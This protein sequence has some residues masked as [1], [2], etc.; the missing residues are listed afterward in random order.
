[1]RHHRLLHGLG[2]QQGWG[3]WLN[4]A[5]ARQVDAGAGLKLDTSLIAFELAAQGSGVALGRSALAG[6]ALAS[7]RLIVPFGLA[8]PIDQAFQLLRTAGSAVHPDAA[9]FVE[10][11]LETAH[12]CRANARLFRPICTLHHRSRASNRLSDQGQSG[13]QV[14]ILNERSDHAGAGRF[15]P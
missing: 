6:P 7:G 3:I 12:L 2:Y 11:L 4:A 10:W 9:A 1:M 13:S 14:L 15:N 5:G 8:V